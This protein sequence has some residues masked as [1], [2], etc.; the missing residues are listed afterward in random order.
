MNSKYKEYYTIASECYLFFGNKVNDKD[1]KKISLL[2]LKLNEYLNKERDI[3]NYE[4]EHINKD[5]IIDWK[6]VSF[7]DGLFI[8]YPPDDRKVMFKPKGIYYPGV[9]TSFNYLKDYLN[10]RLDPIRCSIKDMQLEIIDKI[11]LD[12]ALAKFA[13]SAK[14]RVA[15]LADNS[16]NS[17][18]ITKPKPFK[19]ALSNAQ[20]MSKEE[21][22]QF[23][24]EY[25][26]Y[27]VIVQCKKYK[28]IPCIEHLAYEK[29]GIFES[30]FLFTLKCKSGNLLVVYENINPS[31][32]TLIFKVK[33]IDFMNSVRSVYDF[34]QGDDIN[35][36][37]Y[38]REG[39]IKF[40]NKNILSFSSI[41][42]GYFSSWKAT[43]LYYR[44]YRNYI[45]L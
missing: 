29:S 39:N 15:S 31:R 8:I 40:K 25:I 23:K 16:K 27:L 37:S 21:F 24:S 38:I 44:E 45:Y 9:F 1:I 32:S 5:W 10:N 17:G 13:S 35:K 42:H 30:G 19:K 12:E 43:L 6:C 3:N 41:D 33:N 4:N 28:I 11:K 26:D 7:K 2:S 14:Q 20:I 18:S 34:L 22:Q 36:R